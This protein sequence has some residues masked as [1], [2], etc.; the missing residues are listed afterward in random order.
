MRGAPGMLLRIGYYANRKGFP[1]SDD[2]ECTLS[3]NAL[4][5]LILS[6]EQFAQG[7][8]RMLKH[9]LANVGD[10]V[11]L[12]FKARLERHDWTL[13]F[14]APGKATRE[15]Y[16][17][18]EFVS[19]RFDEANER[20]R[21]SCSLVLTPAELGLLGELRQIRNRVRH[22][23]LKLS[24]EAAGS[25]LARATAYGLDFYA[26][27]LEVVGDEPEDEL[28]ELRKLLGTLEEF[29]EHRLAQVRPEADQLEGIMLLGCPHCSQQMLYSDGECV[30]CLFCRS[31][32]GGED[33]AREWAWRFHPPRSL[34]EELYSPTV[35]QCPECAADACVYVAEQSSPTSSGGH[36]CFACGASGDYFECSD[37]SSLASGSTNPGG[38]CHDCW[39][40][41]VDKHD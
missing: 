14:S 30:R 26:N 39:A 37:C 41:C 16:E 29:V 19:V 34:D 33:A 28:A 13:V 32:M 27:H 8:E 25:L 10:G 11:E 9:A 21:D 4:D 12:L 6:G 20:L 38:R 40:N 2:L 17:S 31:T 3:E 15:R 18:G 24:R 23:R 1:V 22:F 35:L 7:D 36:Y 5:Y